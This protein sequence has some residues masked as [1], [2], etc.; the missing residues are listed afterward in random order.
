[1]KL[2]FCSSHSWQADAWSPCSA[3]C[4]P[5]GTR[6]RTV[7]CRRKESAEVT[8]VLTDDRCTGAKPEA[9]ESCNRID[10]SP[11]WV[12]AEW[13]AVSLISC[14][15]LYIAPDEDPWQEC[16]NVGSW[17]V[18]FSSYS[19]TPLIRPPFG[20]NTL[21]VL[22]RSPEVVVLTGSLDKKNTLILCCSGNNEVVVLTRWSYG[23]VPLYV[24][25][26]FT[27]HSSAKIYAFIW[28]PWTQLL[29]WYFLFSSFSVP[30][31]NA[32]EF[33]RDLCLVKSSWSLVHLKIVRTLTAQVRNP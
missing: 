20:Q 17:A 9:S 15:T 29:P 8:T 24:H 5:S 26:I 11:D 13:S 10:C 23:G 21:V 12:P 30:R 1:M 32:K 14:N 22:T 18:A 19:G 28:M 4:G 33:R 2:F 25:K 16:R 6:T 27:N 7:E 31:T 3:S